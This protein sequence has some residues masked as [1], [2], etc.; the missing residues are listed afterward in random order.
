PVGNRHQRRYRRLDVGYIKQASDITARPR[1]PSTISEPSYPGGAA[2][3]RASGA[4]TQEAIAKREAGFQSALGQTVVTFVAEDPTRILRWFQKRYHPPAPSE[5]RVGA[6][7]S[8]PVRS[9]RS[10]PNERR[11]DEAPRHSLYA[12]P[13]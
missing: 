8:Q 5:E 13:R 11:S 7:L 4:H 12:Q 2:A 6:I 1:C 3:D 9:G 10:P